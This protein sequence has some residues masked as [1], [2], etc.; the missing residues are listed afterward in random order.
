MRPIMIRTAAMTG[1]VLLFALDASAQIERR[2][3]ATGPSLRD[4][5]NDLSAWGT[6]H[7]GGAL[8][9]LLAVGIAVG[10]VLYSKLKR[11]A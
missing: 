7:P 5:I 10:M 2:D 4:F 6:S 3:G 9:L 11:R 1:S 8:A